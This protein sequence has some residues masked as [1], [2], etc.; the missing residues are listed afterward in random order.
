MLQKGMSQVTDYKS[1][2]N[3]RLANSN[4]WEIKGQRFKNRQLMAFIES[5]AQSHTHQQNPCLISD[6]ATD[7]SP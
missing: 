2:P 3:K 7:Q 6:L 4:A 1:H 5:L